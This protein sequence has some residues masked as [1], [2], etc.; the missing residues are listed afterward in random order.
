MHLLALSPNPVDCRVSFSVVSDICV[1]VTVLVFHKLLI[2]YSI[3]SYRR[4]LMFLRLESI[5]IS[6]SLVRCYIPIM[7]TQ[8]HDSNCSI[9]IVLDRFSVGLVAL[10]SGVDANDH[11]SWCHYLSCVPTSRWGCNPKNL[12]CLVINFRETFSYELSKI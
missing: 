11:C 12:T 9:K 1:R 5:S 6:K 7:K 4:L 8:F 10:L 2:L 3:S